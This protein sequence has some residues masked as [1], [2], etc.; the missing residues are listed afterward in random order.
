MVLITQNEYFSLSYVMVVMIKTQKAFILILMDFIFKE[1]QKIE[2]TKF[3]FF[4][5]QRESYMTIRHYITTAHFNRRF[6]SRLF[7]LLHR[8][9]S[10]YRVLHFVIPLYS[11]ML[12]FS[13]FFY[14]LYQINSRNFFEKI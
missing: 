6:H 1:I 2:I 11:M 12:T 8:K 10:F 3:P 14:L 5:I 9:L 7:L 13:H 4:F